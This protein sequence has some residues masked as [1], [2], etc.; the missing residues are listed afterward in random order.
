MESDSSQ[1]GTF[2]DPESV[3]RQ[4]N[5]QKGQCVADFGCGPGYFT[6]PFARAVGE[7]GRVHALDILPQA[8]ETVA[9][10]AGAQGLLN[11]STRRVNLEKEGGSKLNDESVDL[12]MLK[13]M[14]FQN[15]DKET[16]V[17]EI[18][19]VLRPGGRCIVIEWS[20]EAIGIG[21]QSGLR[22]LPDDVNAL[23]AQKGFRFE[24]KLDVGR[25]HYGLVMIK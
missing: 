14:L 6:I 13:D 7:D 2:L 9:S 19:R 10:M 23:F 15:S 1:V 22:I 11:I 3:V 16:I 8:L 21:P 5:I 25:F 18:N 20:K 17:G 24:K 12:V 4:L